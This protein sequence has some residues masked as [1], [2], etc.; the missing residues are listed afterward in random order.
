MKHFTFYASCSA[1]IID[2]IVLEV[3]QLALLFTV[4]YFFVRKCSLCFRIPVHHA[5]A[6]INKAFIIEVYKDFNDAFR[7]SF[8][9]REASSVPIAG[10]TNLAQLFENDTAMF[11]RPIP[12]VLQELFTGEIQFA[13]TLLSEFIYNLCFGC[14]GSVVCSWHPARI[15]SFHSC[16][17]HQDVLNRVVEDVPHMQHSRHVGRGN[18][19][20][21][22]LTTIG[23]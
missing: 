20:G 18:Y 8:V 14:N 17:A 23:F 19:N 3:V 22:R 12:S 13:D 2:H 9:H 6:T 10:S 11:F 4:N 15:L 16:V 5:K 21:V 1:I 7:A